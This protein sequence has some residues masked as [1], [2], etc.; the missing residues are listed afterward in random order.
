MADIQDKKGE[1][2]KAYSHETVEGRWYDWWEA[3]GYF[4]PQRDP[5]KAP[6]TIIMPPPNVT[7]ELHM[8]HALTNAVEDILIRYKRMAGYATLYLPGE[9]HAGIAG[10][11]VVEKELAKEGKT[12][13]DLG[14]EAFLERTW[15]WMNRYRP[16]IRYQLR[17]LG[18]SCDWTRERFTMDPGPARA[19]RVVFKRLYDKGL[20][21]KGEK[22]INWC[23][24]CATTLSDLEVEDVAEEGHLW[25][26]LYPVEDEGRKTKD[27]SGTAP[28]I[29]NP[30]SAIR[31][32]I[33]VATTRPETM[34]G[35]TGV[36]VYPDDPRWRDFI[37]KTVTLP[38]MR[39]PIPVIA[40]EGVEKEFG[41]GA[42]KMTPGHD[43]LD[44]EIGQRHGLPII[45]ILNPDGTL[46]ENAGP[47]AGQTVEEARKGVVAQL[48][49][50]GLL[51]GV[52]KHTHNVPHCDRCGTTVEPIVSDQWF[53]KMQPLAEPAIEAV[54]RGT[55]KIV[56]ERFTKVY[57]HWMEH[58]R[59]WPIS[60]QLWWGHRIPV[61]YCDQGHRF[62]SDQEPE[63]V[64][65]CSECGSASIQQD[66]DVLDTWFSSGLWPFSTLG[67]PDETP[68]YDYFYPTSVMETGYDIIF[69]WVARMIFQG[70]EHTHQAP[71]HTVYLHG[72]V[73]DDKNRKMSK[74]VG[75][76][77]DPLIM[78]DKLGSD[79]LRMAL[80]TNS[81]PGNDQKFSDQR[82]EQAA[83]FANKLWNATR[84]VLGTTKDEGR[85]TNDLPS[86]IVL[87]PSSA[88]ADRW[89]LSRYSR[90]VEET[91]RM[92][93]EY[94]LGEAG[95]MLQEFVWSEY[96]DWYIEAA[97][98]S[99]RS[100]D[101]GQREETSAVAR[102]VLDG[103]LR[104]LHPYMPFLTEELWQNLHGW[105]SQDESLPAEA[106][107]LMMAQWPTS[108]GTDDEAENDFTLVMEI[109]REIR[110]ARAEAVKDAPEHIKKEITGRW[111]EAL[112][113]GGP[114]TAALKR[115]ADTIARLGRLDLSKLIIEESLPAEQRPDKAATLVVR[116]AE[117]ILPLAGLVD[118]DAERKRLQAEAEQT[119]AEI[120]RTGALLANEGFTSRAPAQ[121]VARERAKLAAA[122]ERLAKLRERLGSL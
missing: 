88:L 35:D 31:N 10:Q 68:D 114:R 32:G 23:P 40:D 37:G 81:S 47:Y 7:G 27:E 99:L 54:R 94:Q 98:T 19:V 86:S 101:A 29:R 8:G 67:W 84:F 121:V 79:A 11:N 46:N 77:V 66:P 44:F 56:P 65:R 69:F 108:T 62:A 17:R 122:H 28:Q 18:A 16:R 45:N 41:T 20:I 13:H 76:V 50:E 87:R 30:Q 107:S 26:I 113:A 93:D 105:P 112:I 22:I 74:S 120:A 118:L 58:I 119:E 42:V 25:T 1:M 73:R 102:Y 70:L 43:P 36:A 34:L 85:R 89:I 9:D 33:T 75:N 63:T 24:R 5:N 49:R 39:R 82:I 14:R 48:E 4:T 111:I 116:E 117:V 12:R 53:V 15:E 3:Q 78:A 83:H 95:K 59:D 91:T 2:A 110:N 52:E 57:Y 61:W 90:I 92:L 80:I 115:E 96:C 64:L 97:K 104:L 51:L 100:E 38:I 106:Q 6:Y 72:M 109:I 55:I 21:Y 71:F 103:I 60:R